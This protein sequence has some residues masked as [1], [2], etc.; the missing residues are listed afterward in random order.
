MSAPRSIHLGFELWQG[1]PVAIPIEH[2]V[3][4]GQTQKSGKT[5]TLEALISRSGLRAIS[6]VTK[7]AEQSFR[8]GRRIPPYFK[9]RTDWQFVAAILEATMRER[10]K[11]ERP[12]IIRVCK[13]AASLAQVWANVRAF[14]PQPCP[15]CHGTGAVRRAGSYSAVDECKKCRGTGS[16]AKAHGLSADVYTTLDAYFQ[17]VVPQIEKLPYAQFLELAPGVNVMDLSGYAAELQ[18]LVI[19][20][21]LEWVY[22]H[23]RDVVVVIPEAWQFIPQQRNSPVKMAAE[24]LIRKGASARNYLW[25]DSQDLAGVDKNILRQVGVYILGVQRESN[26]LKRVVEHIPIDA[27][28]RKAILGELARLGIGEFFVSYGRELHKVYVQPSW[29]R[30]DIARATAVV[31]GLANEHTPEAIERREAAALQEEDGMSQAERDEMARLREANREQAE[32]IDELKAKIERLE[33][34]ARN[35][36]GAARA[37]GRPNAPAALAG[38]GGQA[39]EE[40]LAERVLARILELAPRHPGV[41]KVLTTRPELVV[42]VQ[43]A[44]ITT[45]GETLRGRLALMIAEG[46][47]DTPVTG[48]N[49]YSEL[50]GRRGFKTAKPNVY[51]ELDKLAEMGFVTKEAGGYQAVAGMKPRVV[52]R[53]V[54]VMA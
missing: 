51:R 22:H 7:R 17:I 48:N 47:F 20:S 45:D 53:D 27:R 50:Q 3:V 24:E 1:T 32:E 23:E 14:L 16:L 19:R 36:P 26:E 13:G 42:D 15:A 37:D 25:L 54:E 33:A 46:Y 40:A 35:V 10:L 21:V 52:A 28:K 4:T 44:T 49:A 2:M 34:G 30:E 43:R 9:E 41:L 6:F 38:A 39:D 31:G 11:F 8:G 12:W 5:T 18:A 29:E